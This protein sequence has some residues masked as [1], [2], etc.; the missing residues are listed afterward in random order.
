MISDL[1]V[2]FNK[3]ADPF[4]SNMSKFYTH[5]SKRQIKCSHP[6]SDKFDSKDILA[7]WKEKLSKGLQGEV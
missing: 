7:N 3:M 5:I 2:F 4:P 1:R 6:D